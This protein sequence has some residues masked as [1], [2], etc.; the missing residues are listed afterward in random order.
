MSSS[1]S[2]QYAQVP[3]TQVF[4]VTDFILPYQS[5]SILRQLLCRCVCVAE[6]YWCN[7]FR[8]SIIS[9][10]V[11]DLCDLASL[12][13]LA[14]QI[15]AAL[16]LAVWQRRQM[17][18]ERSIS[19]T[20]HIGC[21][22]KIVASFVEKDSTELETAVVLKPTTVVGKKRSSLMCNTAIIILIWNRLPK[23]LAAS[24]EPVQPSRRKFYRV[25]LSFFLEIHAKM[26]FRLKTM[27]TWSLYGFSTTIIS[28]E[29]I[30]LYVQYVNTAKISYARY[31][32]Q[33]QQQQQ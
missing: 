30:L 32:R 23:S 22:W 27:S 17:W 25:S 4:T 19:W 18:A 1:I 10:A 7:A 26:S 11:T 6:S 33:Q 3:S 15:F 9:V 12:L 2:I 21:K 29:L 14:C 5:K 24:P 16:T 13:R 28:S 20:L 8:T 31:L